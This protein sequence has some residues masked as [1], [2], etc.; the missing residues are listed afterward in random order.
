MAFERLVLD[1]AECFGASAPDESGMA[2][3]AAY[4]GR[5][6]TVGWRQDAARRIDDGLAADV[7]KSYRRIARGK[8]TDVATGIGYEAWFDNGKA[9]WF[10]KIQDSP[11]AAPTD[12]DLSGFFGS[13]KFAQFARRCAGYAIAA[14]SVYEEVVHEH[15]KNGELLSVNEQKLESILRSLGVGRFV[16]NL[17][18]CRYGKA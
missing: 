15:L 7:A 16:E 14:K 4:A 13:D 8:F 3:W 10:L 12:D 9:V 1:G 2:G 6:V 18:G 17:R 5:C 11:K